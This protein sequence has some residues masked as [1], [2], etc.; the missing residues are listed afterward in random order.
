MIFISIVLKINLNFYNAWSRIESQGTAQSLG[1]TTISHMLR[2]SVQPKRFTCVFSSNPH[3]KPALIIKSLH[4][5]EEKTEE[6]SLTKP[7]Y[8]ASV[9]HDIGIQT[10]LT[11]V[12]STPQCNSGSQLGHNLPLRGHMTPLVVTTE[13]GC[14]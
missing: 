8:W 1:S 6:K 13:G 12:P 10:A 4:S 2:H 14:L 9:R 11:P 7:S 5:L 3:L